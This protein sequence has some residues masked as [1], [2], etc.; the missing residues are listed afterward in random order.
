M[1]YRQRQNS[2][3]ITSSFASKSL[4]CDRS[5]ILEKWNFVTWGT[6]H[7]TWFHHLTC[8]PV[9]VHCDAAVLCIGWRQVTRLIQ[10]W[11]HIVVSVMN[12]VGARGPV[13]SSHYFR[14][15]GPLNWASGHHKAS[16]FV[17]YSIK[18]AYISIICDNSVT[19]QNW[20][21]LR[22]NF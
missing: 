19:T 22:K 12:S 18:A 20:W 7:F 1:S 8:L 2:W 5:H 13:R 3:N 21:F 4:L 16:V 6:V 14:T 11:F 15:H 9:Y 17:Q 10:L